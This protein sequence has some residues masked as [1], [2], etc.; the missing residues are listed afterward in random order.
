M[1]N[2]LLFSIFLLLL[3]NLK[4]FS[5]S[6]TVDSDTYTPTAL[7]EEVLVAGCLEITNL[8]YTGSNTSIGYF[9]FSGDIES[10]FPFSEGILMSSGDV[11]NA[12]GPNTQSGASSNLQQAGDSDLDALLASQTTQD[13]T[14][15]EFDFVPTNDTIMFRYIFSSE[16][17]PEYA[18]SNFNDIFAFFLSGTNPEGGM[19]ENYNMAILPESDIVVSINNIN[20][21]T[22][23]NGPCENCEY[24][25]Q[26]DNGEYHEYDARTTPLIAMAIVQPMQTYHIKLSIADVGDSSLD[27]GV[28][29]EAGSFDGS[30]TLKTN[31]IGEYMQFCGS[32]IEIPDSVNL[33]VTSNLDPYVNY[34]WQH[35]G[36]TASEVKVAVHESGTMVYEVAASFCGSEIVA[37]STIVVSSFEGIDLTTTAASCSYNND[38]SV[39][40]ST[41]DGVEPFSYFWS[42]NL[43][44]TTVSEVNNIAGGT[45]NIEVRDGNGC[46][47]DSTFVV[48]KPQ[49]INIAFSAEHDVYD[50]CAGS[51]SA[52][53]SGGVS[54]YTYSWEHT[55]DNILSLTNLCE[56]IYT[57]NVTDFTDCISEKSQQIVVFY[58]GKEEINEISK[59][60]KIYPNPI[61]NGK[62]SVVLDKKYNE[63]VELEII[64]LKG[65]TV[66]KN[67]FKEKEIKKQFNIS[68]LKEGIYLLKLND[69]KTNFF[70][71]KLIIKN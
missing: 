5:Q 40:I 57:L 30:A 60:S 25:E 47:F 6:I 71:E 44:D 24:Y 7:V 21:G 35:D 20:N 23:N 39:S 52:S 68:F 27:S 54:P 13:A 70:N 16:E 18:N 55:E 49:A 53:I 64:D 63:I 59:T 15:L 48:P 17:Y 33:E 62:F 42:N 45:Y 41:E 46:T 67:Y 10:G 61:E 11:T 32:A 51:I 26:E 36:T 43:A 58:V 1:K 69:S 66:Y 8:Q 50:E 28:F 65:N 14:I 56:G 9:G 34:V 37:T 2:K 19:Y 29:L 31:M 4:L 22:S 12:L 3:F 38:G